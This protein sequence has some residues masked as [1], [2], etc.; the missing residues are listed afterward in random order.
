MVTMCEEPQFAKTLGNVK[1]SQRKGLLYEAQ[2]IKA[3][4]DDLGKGWESLPGPWFEFVDSRGHR[5]A[6]ADWVGF[7]WHR[8]LICI[9]EMKLT[10]VPEA[11]W[12]LNRL[13]QPLIHRL[14][15]R[16]DIALVEITANMYNVAL[17]EPV[18]VIH[19]LDAVEPWK[20]SVMVVPYGSH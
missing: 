1:G 19:S 10:R 13:Y 9:A 5:Y 15:P 4:D 6:Q 12:Q 2:V 18:K 11:W 16:W 8:G 20:T 14:F 7:N 3:L 17:P